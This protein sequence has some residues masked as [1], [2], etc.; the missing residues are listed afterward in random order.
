MTKA[1]LSD[2]I[3]LEHYLDFVSRR[4]RTAELRARAQLL[5]ASIRML[6][7]RLPRWRAELLAA[8]DVEDFSAEKLITILPETPVECNERELFSNFLNQFLKQGK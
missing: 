5:M 2:L 6:D 7:A 3:F 4:G 8:L 1:S